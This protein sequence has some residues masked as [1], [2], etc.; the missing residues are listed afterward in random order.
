[1]D[2]L[3]DLN[4]ATSV[5]LAPYAFVPALSASLGINGECHKQHRQPMGTKGGNAGV[6]CRVKRNHERHHLHQ[7]M[8]MLAPPNLGLV[9]P[10]H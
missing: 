6:L 7:A 8:L 5:V 3:A 2:D 1:M 4:S 10:C 9:R